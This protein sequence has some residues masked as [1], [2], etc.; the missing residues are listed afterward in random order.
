MRF[1]QLRKDYFD[2]IIEVFHLADADRRAVLF[3]VTADRCRIGLTAIDRV[4][5]LQPAA[6]SVVYP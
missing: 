5:Y 2:N 1:C 4:V 6:N 3:V